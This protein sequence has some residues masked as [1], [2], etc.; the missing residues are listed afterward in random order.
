LVMMGRE[1]ANGG[2]AAY[3][4]KNHSIAQNPRPS[5]IRRYRGAWERN[6]L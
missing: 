5:R 3:D 4:G 6:L 2:Q 1:D